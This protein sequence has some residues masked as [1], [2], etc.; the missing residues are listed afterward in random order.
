MD[1]RN[2]AILIT[3]L[4]VA[5]NGCSPPSVLVRTQIDETEKNWIDFELGRINFSPKTKLLSAI[6]IETEID[7]FQG[8]NLKIFP[9]SLKIFLNGIEYDISVYS[10]SGKIYSGQSFSGE[11]NTFTIDCYFDQT[12]FAL[13]DTI[14]LSTAGFLSND[15]NQISLPE[16]YFIVDS[17]LVK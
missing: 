8:R 5:F 6:Y 7:I 17:V 11:N 2:I 10:N 16:V 1:T 12:F 9:D 4:F 13:G 14:K 15:S 3:I